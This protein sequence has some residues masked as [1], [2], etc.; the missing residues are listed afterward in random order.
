MSMTIRKEIK[1]SDESVLPPIKAKVGEIVEISVPSN[2]TT[3]F[4]CTL[5]KMPD[6]LYL[7]SMDYVPH[8]PEI[9]GSGGTKLFKFVAV[10]EGNGGVEFLDV[11]FSNPLEFARQTPMQKRFVIVG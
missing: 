3:G 10:K 8:T 9:I 11:K 7:V 1:M 6:C 2:P 5:T 4:A